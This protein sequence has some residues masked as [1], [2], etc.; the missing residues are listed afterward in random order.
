MIVT[1]PF[2]RISLLEGTT[3]WNFK[4]TEYFTPIGYDENQNL[5][6]CMWSLAPVAKQK[7]VYLGTDVLSLVPPAHII[8][9]VF[10]LCWIIAASP[11]HI[12]QRIHFARPT[13][14]CWFVWIL[15]DTG[16]GE[17]LQRVRERLCLVFPTLCF[18]SVLSLLNY[19]ISLKIS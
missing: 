16:I 5:R 10:I 7:D 9:N 19:H 1:K 3:L 14:P 11:G 15:P 12:G 18:V 2:Y 4:I 6:L 8:L 13:Q 17:K